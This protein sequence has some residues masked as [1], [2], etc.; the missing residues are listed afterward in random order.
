[1]GYL[2]SSFLPRSK[3]EMSHE[4]GALPD[5]GEEHSYY[6]SQGI[7]AEMNLCQNPTKITLIFHQFPPDTSETLS[8]NFLPLAQTLF[9][10]VLSHLL[11]FSLF[12]K[13]VYK[14]LSRI[15]L[16]NFTAFLSA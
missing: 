16:L 4:K 5:R 2:P 13:M 14:P 15:T 9:S 3:A 7:D 6:P 12:V 11:N 1:M 8:P 10:F